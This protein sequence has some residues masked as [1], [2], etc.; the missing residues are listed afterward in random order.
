ML[1]DSLH[2]HVAHRLGL[3]PLVF[4]KRKGKVIRLETH[5][6]MSIAFQNL[7]TN[8]DPAS[9]RLVQAG[10]ELWRA[11]LGKRS[12]LTFVLTQPRF[13]VP[14]MILGVSTHTTIVTVCRERHTALVSH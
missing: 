8:F 2:S 6:I 12:V 13:F 11:W 9:K 4:Q 10:R 1:D 5:T 7:L 3:V 14:D